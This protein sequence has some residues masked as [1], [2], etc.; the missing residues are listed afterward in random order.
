MLLDYGVSFAIDGQE[1]LG[2]ILSIYALIYFDV[3][4]WAQF[5]DDQDCST[6][7]ETPALSISALGYN[8]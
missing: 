1:V 6:L 2:L 8:I 7:T 3:L 5:N 4:R